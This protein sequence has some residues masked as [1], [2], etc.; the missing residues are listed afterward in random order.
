MKRQVLHIPKT[1]ASRTTKYLIIILLLVS[2]LSSAAPTFATPP[3]MPSWP[4]PITAY[5]VFVYFPDANGRFEIEVLC[6]ANFDISWL[7]LQVAHTEEIIFDE[8]L[9][10]FTGGMKVGESKVWRI[11]GRVHGAAL[12]DDFEM[13]A[14]ANLV[15]EYLFPYESIL[16]DIEKQYDP[17]TRQT[18]LQELQER[19]DKTVTILRAI[20]VELPK[21]VALTPADIT[22]VDG[23]ASLPPGAKFAAVD[24]DFRTPG[25]FTVRFKFPADYRIPPHWHP[26]DQRITVIAGTLNIRLEDRLASPYEKI[27]PIGSFAMMPA[28]SIYVAWTE[29]K[30]IIQIHGFGPWRTNYV[31][32]LDD[33]R[34]K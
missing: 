19:R 12:I 7:S 11:K 29:E 21:T 23:P 8:E 28:K 17:Y 27:L 4:D 15:V 31:S 22:W 20:P 18:L 9:P 25:P 14:S 5:I 32:P 34:E 2:L 30:T 3:E 16:K 10:S 1:L 33:S 6:E 26:A 13:P 24:E